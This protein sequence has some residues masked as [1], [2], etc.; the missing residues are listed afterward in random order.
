MKETKGGSKMD[1]PWYV[2]PRKPPPR[3]RGR[4]MQRGWITGALFGAIGGFQIICGM[5]IWIAALYTIAAI[6]VADVWMSR[7]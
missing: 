2:I 1:T 7:R 4:F 3:P 5:P 6:L